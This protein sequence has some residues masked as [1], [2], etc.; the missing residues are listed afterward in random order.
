MNSVTTH[1]TSATA[2]YL[3]SEHCLHAYFTW[4]Y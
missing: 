1:V 2:E 4:Q 3:V